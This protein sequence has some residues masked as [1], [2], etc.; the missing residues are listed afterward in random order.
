MKRI[1]TTIFFIFFACCSI[2]HA[3]DYFEFI[4]IYRGFMVYEDGDFCYYTLDGKQKIE[5]LDYIK[6]LGGRY[7]YRQDKNKIYC[8]D[9]SVGKES[10]IMDFGLEV[11][12][13]F[14]LYDG[15]NVV[16]EQCSDTLVTHND[17]QILCKK[18]HVR[19]LEQSDFTDVWIEGIGSLKYG[20]NPPKAGECHLLHNSLY[21]EQCHFCDDC[22]FTF[23]FQE[24]NLC[25]MDVMLGEEVYKSNFPNVQ[26]YQNAFEDKLLEF[27]LTNDTLH[28]GGYVGTYCKK[29]LYLLFVEI[30]DAIYVYSVGFPLA[31]EADGRAVNIIDVKIPGFTQNSYNVHW[32]GRIF[33]VSRK[34]ASVSTIKDKTY[35]TPYYDLTGREIANPTRDIYIKDGR[36]V[37]IK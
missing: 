31:P 21:L 26:E 18:I 23:D 14:T 11:G 30:A 1:F 16:V 25:G 32:Y 29:S 3:Q 7:C 20:I 8:Y 5:G 36:K 9:C 2:L 12:D 4:E 27:E 28:I 13:I 22:T 37:V 10:L 19:G 6:E 34:G 15:L 24:E 35:T 33:P 17:V